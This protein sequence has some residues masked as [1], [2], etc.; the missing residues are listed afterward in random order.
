MKK[1]L[2]KI[3]RLFARE[4]SEEQMQMWDD[5]KDDYDGDPEF[6]PSLN[7]DIMYYIEL[8][9]QKAKDKYLYDLMKRREAAHNKHK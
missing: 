7:I 1:I 9:T 2:T 5:L 3:K 4:K 8:E 6:H